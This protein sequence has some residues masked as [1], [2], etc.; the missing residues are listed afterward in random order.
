[1]GRLVQ[2]HAV[3]ECRVGAYDSR[4]GGPMRLQFFRRGSGVMGHFS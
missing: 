4:D 1:M 2:T 3:T